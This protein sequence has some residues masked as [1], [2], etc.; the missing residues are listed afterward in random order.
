[1]FGVMATASA[2]LHAG[3][4]AY[5]EWQDRRSGLA[6]KYTDV[7]YWVMADAAEL[8]LSGRSPFDRPTYRYSPLL[9]ILL[10][11]NHWLGELWGKALFSALDI[12]CAFFIYDL[13]KRQHWSTGRATMITSLLWACNPFI[14][15]VSTRGNAESLVCGLTLL[16][17][18]CLA[19]GMRTMAAVVLGL[20]VHVKMFPMLYLPTV[21]VFM[22]ILP[23]RGGPD[24]SSSNTAPNSPTLLATP[25]KKPSAMNLGTP[26]KRGDD[27]NNSLLLD[28]KWKHVKFA[29]T[30]AAVFGVCTAMVYGFFGW[31]AIE[32]SIIYHVRRRDHRHNFSVYWLMFYHNATL[33]LPEVWISMVPFIPQ[34]V[35]SLFLA[36][37]YGRRDF[38]F[39]CFLQTFL[40]VSMN[41]VCTSQVRLMPHFSSSLPS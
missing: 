37:K 18:W 41:K 12:V 25:I 7:D 28:V 9:A 21:L 34:L 29:C 3:F 22:G 38:C 30:A 19:R 1:M 32:D 17:I 2:L 5:G 10:L 23:E 35:L 20:A 33:K 16:V 11:P 15:V 8:L 14:L 24:S 4:L 31:K 39:A 13:L 40:F 36:V 6:V 27:P 26:I